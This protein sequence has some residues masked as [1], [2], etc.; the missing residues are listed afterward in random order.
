MDLLIPQ[1]LSLIVAVC[2]CR[3]ALSLKKLVASIHEGARLNLGI[4]GE[5]SYRISG[6]D[7]RK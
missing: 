5:R 4:A 2:S 1:P 3:K 6:A 7:V